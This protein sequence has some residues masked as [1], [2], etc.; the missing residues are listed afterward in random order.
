MTTVGMDYRSIV[1]LCRS[2]SSSRVLNLYQ[3][4]Q[5]MRFQ[6][7]QYDGDAI[8]RSHKLNQ[9]IIIKAR[10]NGA[11]K[12][13]FQ[14]SRSQGTKIF[15]LYDET[16]LRT[17]GKSLFINELAFFE[18]LQDNFGI[19]YFMDEENSRFDIEALN[20][21]DK[22]PSLD[23]F[24]LRERLRMAGRNTAKE[25]FEISSGDYLRIKEFV[26]S[27]L[28]PLAELSAENDYEAAQFANVICERLWDGSDTKSLSPLLKSVDI[29]EVEAPEALFA[30]KGLIYYKFIMSMLEKDFES[31]RRDFQ[32]IKLVKYGD[33]SDASTINTLKGEV[34]Q[35]LEAHLQAGKQA[36]EH[37]QKAYHVNFLREHNALALKEFLKTAPQIFN[38]VGPAISA[39]SHAVSYWNY[40]FKNEVILVCEAREFE[41]ILLDFVH[42]ASSG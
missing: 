1:S 39:V 29:S 6:A 40:R 21:I 12:N 33:G 32:K 20:L 13:L 22:T 27:E 26:V 9:S 11:E 42:G 18:L 38:S 31:L 24:L 7:Q 16:D 5:K 2:S 19:D 30:W 36:L 25:W 35:I 41:E 8:F 28:K 4:S 17:G 3:K 37:Y 15:I 14:A 10:L 23:P 34:I